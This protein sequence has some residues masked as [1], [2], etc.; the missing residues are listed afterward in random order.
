MPNTGRTMPRA[1]SMRSATTAE[2]VGP[3]PA[4]RPSYIMLS[5]KSQS[6]TTALNTPETLAIGSTL[7]TMQGRSEEHTSELQSLMRISYAA[8]CL[9]KKR[10]DANPFIRR[11][12]LPLY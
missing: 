6:A 11:Y 3:A 10:D 5:T 9:Q 2:A 4:P 1:M 12:Q 7:A 8:F